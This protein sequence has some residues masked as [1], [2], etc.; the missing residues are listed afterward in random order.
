MSIPGFRDDA[1]PAEL[2]RLLKR[3]RK[4]EESGG[5]THYGM[6]PY[7]GKYSIKKNDKHLFYTLLYNAIY[8]GKEVCLIEVHKPFGPVVVDI[9]L[10]YKPDDDD[11]TEKGM[12]H[13][14]TEEMV[15]ALIRLYREV[16][17]RYYELPPRQ[18]EVLL[19]EKPQPTMQ[20]GLCKDGIHLMFPELC[21]T[22]DMQKLLRKKVLR[23]LQDENILQE[24]RAENSLE[25]ILDE[26]VIESNGWMVY[27]CKK[28]GGLKYT[29]TGIYDEKMRKLDPSEYLQR[30]EREHS[31]NLIQYLSIRKFTEEDIAVLKPGITKE[32]VETEM[33]TYGVKNQEREVRPTAKKRDPLA[34]SVE[35]RVRAETGNVALARQLVRMLSS[36][37]AYNYHDWIQ[38]GMCLHS[39]S[40]TLV[41][42]WDEFSRQCPEKYVEG[43]CY[44]RW[45]K[46]RR[47]EL[48]IG[49][50]FYWAK[51]DS[52]A[53]YK[54]FKQEQ[55][56]RSIDAVLY[57]PSET[58]MAELIYH[59]YKDFYTCV[60][61]SND[62]WIWY[63]FN[64]LLWKN[65]GTMGRNLMLRVEK[66]MQAMFEAELRRLLN[67]KDAAKSA[68][69]AAASSNFDSDAEHDPD[70]ARE[71][72]KFEA[73]ATHCER[74]IKNLQKV[75]LPNLGKHNYLKLVIHH[76]G[77]HFHD[78]HF[79]NRL[80]KKL[81][82]IC[83]S[84]GVYDLKAGAF[85]EG[86]YED[87]LSICTGIEY[88]T[89]EQIP[90]YYEA[91]Y[92]MLRENH[93]DEQ[94][95]QYLLMLYASC[96][97]GNR[98][99]ESFHI[100]KGKGANGK[101]IETTLLKTAFGEYYANISPSMLTQKRA[102]SSAPQADLLRLKGKRIVVAEEPDKNE[103]LNTGMMKELT[104][105]GTL[106]ARTLYSAEMISFDCNFV[107]FLCTNTYP[108]IHTTDGGTWRRIK[109]IEYPCKYVLN[110]Q[111][112]QPNNALVKRGDPMLKSKVRTEEYGMG[113]M[114]LLIDHYQHFK[115]RGLYP[116]P[117]VR[118]ASE[119]YQKQS[120]MY[121]SF[122]KDMLEQTDDPQ[123]RI[124]M[125]DMFSAFREWYLD[126]CGKK[127]AV[128]R[129]EFADC[130]RK[131]LGM[132]DNSQ[133]VVGFRR[134]TVDYESKETM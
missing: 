31:V 81:H 113:L 46:F 47:K 61:T 115:N 38:L 25:D 80:D 125:K 89:K 48:K 19:M 93:P 23:R 87:Y 104:G 65:Q 130:I 69:E 67:R 71:E 30:V 45:S 29:I 14:Y 51:K 60:P 91:V 90:E 40:E 9:D 13:R 2:M 18:L 62:R 16:I 35:E 100:L 15:H 5:V 74:Y 82:L 42:L 3:S 96:L 63:E 83:F 76:S 84:N 34:L 92:S 55:N 11:V 120:N 131:E 8:A 98:E 114:S 36:E 103:T 49:T 32:M 132:Q 124:H 6:G 126:A 73:E 54:K 28:V 43:D 112:L 117:N 129:N 128:N 106:T 24:V 127:V 118:A 39:I 78:E 122:V 44:E 33:F 12:K 88:R 107:L 57:N 105:G 7:A 97:Q 111:E 59:M 70:A 68:A 108:A 37:R 85:R 50:L 77:Y 95:F 66:D 52:P 58:R 119:E 10:K 26:A 41:D 79:L 1:L 133:I 94:D 4:S 22:N 27:G 101:T 75:I 102:A 53:E 110:E 56:K 20:N 64:G 21:L 116:P 121:L 123:D 109:V 134:R 86:L 17:S 72:S 99:E